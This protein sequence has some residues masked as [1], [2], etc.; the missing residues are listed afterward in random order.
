MLVDEARASC[1]QVQ[2]GGFFRGACSVMPHHV[3]RMLLSLGGA[4]LREAAVLQPANDRPI[5]RG[6]LAA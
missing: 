2:A 4:P 1:T 5:A 3:S 6:N